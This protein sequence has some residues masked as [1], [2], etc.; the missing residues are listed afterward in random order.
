MGESFIIANLDKREYLFPLEVGDGNQITEVM[1]H[2]TSLKCLTLLLSVQKNDNPIVGR[3][4]GDRIAIVGDNG[5]DGEHLP[6]DWKGQVRVATGRAVPRTECMG[7]VPSLRRQHDRIRNRRVDRRSVHGEGAARRG[8]PRRVPR[9]TFQ[10]ASKRLLHRQEPRLRRPDGV[11][12]VD[13]RRTNATRRVA[14]HTVHV[15]SGAGG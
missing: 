5:A 9:G 10:A 2:G 11:R 3:W 13:N 14:G 4:A 8:E 12:S 1:T 6:E 15:R 7:M